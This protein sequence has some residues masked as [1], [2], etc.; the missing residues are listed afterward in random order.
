MGSLTWLDDTT[1]FPHPDNAMPEGLLAAGATLSVERLTQAYRQGIFPWFNPG[2]PV[3]WWSPDP[4]MVLACADLKVSHSLAKK[5][6]QAARLETTGAARLRITTDTAFSSVIQACAEPR[7]DQH[8]T[9]ISPSIQRVYLDWHLAGCAHSIETWVDGR[10][11]GGLYGVCLGRFF[12]GESMFSKVPDAS[13]LALV[14]LVRY[15]QAQGVSHIDCQQQTRHL[16]S[17]GARPISRGAFMALLE[18]RLDLPPPDWR[19]GQ[20]LADGTLAPL[21]ENA[22]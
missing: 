15:L 2:D 9:W 5:L 10:L 22:P 18:E 3:L 11:A 16:A 8:G 4:R 21:E 1:P 17:M 6:R 14:Y 7:A 12:F 19:P 20:L 13:K